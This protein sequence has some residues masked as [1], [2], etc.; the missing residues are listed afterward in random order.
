[1]IA[2]KCFIKMNRENT[3]TYSFPYTIYL[4]HK[5]T[6]VKAR[7]SDK[8][9]PR[10]V[11]GPQSSCCGSTITA[12]GDMCST[13]MAAPCIIDDA[14]ASCK[15]LSKNRARS[16][17]GSSRVAWLFYV[18][19]TSYRGLQLSVVCGSI[20][21][22]ASK[23]YAGCCIFSGVNAYARRHSASGVVRR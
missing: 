13:T 12:S 7:S 11:P 6:L 3:I 17:L 22:F 9:I 15:S 20:P 10:P 16:L 5:H 14:G 4:N 19:T 8:L 21:A 18:C 1:M 2:S 23:K